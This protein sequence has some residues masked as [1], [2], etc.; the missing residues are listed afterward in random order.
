LVSADG[1]GAIMS[2]G[3]GKTGI[4]LLML[5]V[6]SVLRDYQVIVLGFADREQTEE[7]QDSGSR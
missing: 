7:C 4:G 6:V 5:P 1:T 2:F 3:F